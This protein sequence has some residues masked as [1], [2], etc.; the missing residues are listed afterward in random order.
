MCSVVGITG[1]TP[2]GV[3]VMVA[4]IAPHGVAV[5]V[6]AL[7]GA[8]VTITIIAGVVVGGWAMVGPGGRGH[9]MSISKEGGEG[10]W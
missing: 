9:Y 5:T 10:P 8:A 7:H 4:V 1:V 3:V 6:I 2:H